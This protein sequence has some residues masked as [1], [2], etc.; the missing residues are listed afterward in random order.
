MLTWAWA[1]RLAGA[2]VTANAL[3]PG[4]TRTDAFGKGGGWRARV[5]ALGA[6]V[7]GRSPERSA[8]TAVWLASSRQLEHVTGRFWK[9]RR[10][11]GCPYKNPDQEE[12]LWRLCE[13]MTSSESARLQAVAS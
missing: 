11:L 10:E 12:A 4:F 9:D 13:Q 7:F 8:D 3:H 2:G 1:R 6:R 5:A